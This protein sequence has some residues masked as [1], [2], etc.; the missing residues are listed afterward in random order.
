MIVFGNSTD[1]SD[2][3]KILI[4]TDILIDVANNNMIAKVRLTNE[5]QISFGSIQQTST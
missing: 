5:S 2:M 1:M 3:P 4:G